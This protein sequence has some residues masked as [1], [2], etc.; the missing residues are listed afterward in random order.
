MLRIRVDVVDHRHGVGCDEYIAAREEIR[1]WEEV[2]VEG[3]RPMV[4]AV[5]HRKKEEAGG[6]HV[7]EELGVDP[8]AIALGWEELEPIFSLPSFFF[9]R[10]RLR[11]EG[12]TSGCRLRAGCCSHPRSCH[13]GSRL[14]H[15]EAS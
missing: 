13:Q 11:R 4:S 5:A 8:P 6:A 3:L 10:A 2:R 7:V 1:H 12:R 14:T 9:S 15:P